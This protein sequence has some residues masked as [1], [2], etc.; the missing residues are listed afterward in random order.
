[1]SR[2][3]NSVPST[4]SQPNARADDRLFHPKPVTL[5]D[6]RVRLE[7]LQAQ[8]APGLYAVGRASRIWEFLPGVLF[9]DL[10]DAA[11]WIDGTR[12]ETDSG[13]RIAFAIVDLGANCIA[14]STSY[15]DITRDH[16][17]LEI[18]WTWLGIAYQRT[19]INTVCKF[20]LLR[21]AFEVLGAIRVQFKTDRCNTRSRQ[22]IERIGGAFEGIHR[23]H[24][25]LPDG[26]IRATAFYSIT[27]SEWNSSIKDRLIRLQGKA[28]VQATARGGASNVEQ[29]IVE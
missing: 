22:A 12:R 2:P 18:G 23:N 19:F 6:E 7:P 28:A 26:K 27:D 20:L 9:R 15:L 21:H 1:M 8:H 14:G 24:M 29:S 16:R 10:D 25:I 13:K 4:L 17:M 5:Q 11:S 3:T